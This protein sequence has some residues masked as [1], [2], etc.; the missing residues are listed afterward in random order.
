VRTH[1]GVAILLLVI[2]I[3]VL[4]LAFKVSPY[5]ARDA[6]F[7]RQDELLQYGTQPFSG[8]LI[9]RYENGLLYRKTDYRAG[10]KHGLSRQYALNGNL[11]AFGHYV[12]GRREGVEQG[13][14]A[15]GGKKFEYHYKHGVFDGV[16]MQWHS[17]GAVFRREVFDNGA[18]TE[19][20]ILYPHGEIFTNYAIRDGR[21]YGLD[22]G[23]LCMETKRDGEK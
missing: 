1:S 20:K 15:E 10:I 18:E 9:E 5:E 6:G 14:F 16:Q 4:A 22:G 13:W 23:S 7:S 8:T 21:T 19:K 11:V 12:D 2:T 17:S 3:I